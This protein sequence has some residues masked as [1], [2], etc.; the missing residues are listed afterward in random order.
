LA[1]QLHQQEDA[2]VPAHIREAPPVLPPG[3]AAIRG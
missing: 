3:V 1:T 2:A